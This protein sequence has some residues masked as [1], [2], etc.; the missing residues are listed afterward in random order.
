[1]F[2]LI[3]FT[4]LCNPTF[5]V[6][7]CL[8]ENISE[9]VISIYAIKNCRYYYTVCQNGAGFEEDMDVKEFDKDTNRVL[10]KDWEPSKY[11]KPHSKRITK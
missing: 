5:K 9:A 7:T 10:C 2:S 4:S 3:L 6:N 8:V 11:I 1:M